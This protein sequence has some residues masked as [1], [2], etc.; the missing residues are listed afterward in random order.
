MRAPAPGCPPH[1]PLSPA[2]HAPLLPD[3]RG[4]GGLDAWRKQQEGR[5]AS[6]GA[7]G[8]RRAGCEAAELPRGG[9]RA[10]C[11]AAELPRGAER[12]RPSPTGG[13]APP[14]LA[15]RLQR[16]QLR[17]TARLSTHRKVLI[18]RHTHG[19]KRGGSA[20]ELPML[21]GGRG[22]C[23]AHTRG[24]GARAASSGGQELTRCAGTGWEDGGHE[25][26][27]HL[28]APAAARTAAVHPRC[29]CCRQR[30]PSRSASAIEQKP[31]VPGRSSAPSAPPGCV[32]RHTASR[33]RH[34]QWQR[35]AHSTTLQGLEDLPA[36]SSSTQQAVRR[37][38]LCSMHRQNL[39][40]RTATAHA[41]VAKLRHAQATLVPLRGTRPSSAVYLQPADPRVVRNE[42]PAVPGAMP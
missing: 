30:A 20:Y 38:Q 2:A 40:A 7:R 3:W 16:R 5:T 18:D 4:S 26:G 13:S 19:G 8:S 25:T 22:A 36:R 21:S 28:T 24:G 14:A 35:T 6:S 39:S 12:E 34:R 10:G 42:L 11:E 31:A 37:L 23:A 33:V 9:C 1:P 15:A 17:R 27:A 41:C 29:R 32:A